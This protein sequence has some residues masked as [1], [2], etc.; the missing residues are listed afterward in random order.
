MIIGMQPRPTC[1]AVS[2]SGE[3]GIAT[4]AVT[5]PKAKR[6]AAPSAEGRNGILEWLVGR[7]APAG[8][9]TNWEVG[10]PNQWLGS[11][12]DGLMM[13]GYGPVWND[14]TQNTPMGY[15]VEIGV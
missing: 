15:F 9:Y 2:A 8:Q 11:N 12:E 4:C 10:E 6:M 14:G 7:S 3:S 13:W 1:Q 5:V